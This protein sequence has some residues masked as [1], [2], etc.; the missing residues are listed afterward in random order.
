MDAEN[1]VESEVNQDYDVEINELINQE[2]GFFNKMKIDDKNTETVDYEKEMTEIDKMKLKIKEFRENSIFEKGQYILKKEQ[3]SDSSSDEDSDDELAQEYDRIFAQ[4]HLKGS[5]SNYENEKSKSKT[6]HYSINTNKNVSQVI[7]REKLNKERDLVENPIE[8]NLDIEEIEDNI[9][10]ISDDEDE[11]NVDDKKWRRIIDSMTN[12]NDFTSP[13][14]ETQV[15][16]AAETPRDYQ[17]TLFEKAKKENIIAVLNTG[18]GKTLIAVM[19]IKYTIDEE[20]KSLAKSYYL[21]KMMDDSVRFDNIKLKKKIFFLVPVVP[22]VEQQANYIK[23]ILDV[24][25]GKLSGDMSIDSWP[26]ERYEEELN[27]YDIIVATPRSF[28]IC[29]SC[30]G[31]VMSDISLIIF[32]ECHHARGRSVYSSIIATFYVNLP[33]KNKPRIFAMTATPLA[34]KDTDIDTSLNKLESAI[35]CRAYMPSPGEIT[36]FIRKLPKVSLEK[37]SGNNYT[38]DIEFKKMLYHLQQ[39]YVIPIKQ[40]KII[41]NEAT[42]LEKELGSYIAKHY[43]IKNLLHLSNIAETINF[44]KPELN[45]DLFLLAEAS[46]A[47]QKIAKEYENSYSKYLKKMEINNKT[48]SHKVMVLLKCIME[49]YAIKETFCGIIFTKQRCVALA[50][51]EIVS[52]YKPLQSWIKCDFIIGNNTKSIR[53]ISSARHQRK[54][55]Q[56]FS[57]H[58]LNL[59]VATSVAE[60]GLDIQ[61]CN[62][63]IRFNVPE[64]QIRLI[65]S[66]GRA[67]D[68]ASEF[69]VLVGNA[70]EKFLFDSLLNQELQLKSYLERKQDKERPDIAKSEL[71]IGDD[72]MYVVDSTGAL[73]TVNTSIPSVYRYCSLLPSERFIS[74]RPI[75]SIKKCLKTFLYTATVVL[76]MS[77]PE[78][79]RSA[80]GMSRAGKR[81][82]VRYCCLELIKK[83]HAHKELDDYLKPLTIEV[84]LSTFNDDIG[85]GSVN[86]VNKSIDVSVFSLRNPY[87]FLITWPTT[88]FY[89][90]CVFISE[91]RYPID[92]LDSIKNDMNFDIYDEIT[93]SFAFLTTT[94]PLNKLLLL[95]AENDQIVPVY[96]KTIESPCIF[97]D[98]EVDKMKKFH[99]NWMRILLRTK[100]SDDIE[101]AVLCTPLQ[102]ISL[103]DLNNSSST[104]LKNKI[105]WEALDFSYLDHKEGA[106]HI[107]NMCK[108]RDFKTFVL[109][110]KVYYD[111]RYILHEKFENIMPKEFKHEELK[112]PN[113]KLFYE[114]RLECKHEIED[115]QLIFKAATIPYIYQNISEKKSTNSA[116]LLS[117]FCKVS[118]ILRRYLEG[119][120]LLL[121]LILQLSQHSELAL[122]LCDGIN[123]ETNEIIVTASAVDTVPENVRIVCHPLDIQCALLSPI[124]NLPYS[125]ERLEFL[126]DSFLKM[127]QTTELFIR[128]LNR[129]EGVLTKV[130][131]ALERNTSLTAQAVS[132]GLNEYILC[133]PLSRQ[134]YVPPSI[135]YPSQEGRIKGKPIADVL[136]AVIGAACRGGGV[137]NAA[138]AVKRFI[139]HNYEVE[140]EKYKVTYYETLGV[141]G[142]VSN[143]GEALIAQEKLGYEFNDISLM[144]EALTHPSSSTFSR[145]RSYQRLEFLGD[146]VL[147][148]VVSRYVYEYDHKL[149]PGDLTNIKAELVSNNILGFVS[150]QIGLPKL[151]KQFLNSMNASLNEYGENYDSWI[152]RMEKPTYELPDR[153]RYLPWNKSGCTP[154]YLGDLVEASL[155]AIFVDSNFNVEEVWKVVKRFIIDPFFETI[156]KVYKN[157]KIRIEKLCLQFGEDAIIHLNDLINGWS[158][159]HL[160][161]SNCELLNGKPTVSI[162]WHSIIIGV[163]KGGNKKEA[164]SLAVAYALAFF[165]DNKQC[166]CKQRIENGTRTHPTKP[167]R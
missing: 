1:D 129:N 79:V 89:I 37:F 14:L 72:D 82:A 24:R 139:G 108:E 113:L 135:N 60:E 23:R 7:E 49:R 114:K 167:Y 32:D 66:R 162:S 158:C 132:L 134:M 30:V 130:R 128:F 55:L 28:E 78:K 153:Y 65:Q 104:D 140:W 133:T 70:E 9:D 115:K 118:P 163:G 38:E 4:R 99:D 69:I 121:P 58:K 54:V 84:F 145:G 157:N 101:F 149:S 107:F 160:F 142:F 73:V 47:V 138:L 127:H 27:K 154:K 92:I 25:V 96:I 33:E 59:I 74:S 75:F 5:Y 71:I 148:Y 52:S 19:L 119:N 93:A 36:S 6:I 85:L 152:K 126:G 11:D 147:G 46:R 8:D 35:K 91:R 100:L 48:V 22:L 3:E 18:F 111:R 86:F 31:I 95:P 53:N 2:L 34:G 164:K 120:C 68:A 112:F 144:A 45:D 83:L 94:E 166:R 62:I 41:I 61:R 80:T 131:N 56:K 116:F 151:I 81:E 136:E 26:R 16:T 155:G 165:E 143:E 109:H 103:L 42:A 159:K 40:I 15:L 67:R 125:Y 29:L 39:C 13:E 122:E 98:I 20:L 146:A 64:T 137:K 51:S 57:S 12:E 77:V 161:I 50:L 63:V 90:N 44:G 88:K 102:N 17:L 156:Y 43:L 117:Q 105:D 123:K 150:W 106:E 87:S 10:D 110:D 21:K 141:T 76:P 97:D 124:A